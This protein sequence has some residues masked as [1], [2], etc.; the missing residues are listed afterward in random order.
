MAAKKR[1][2]NDKISYSN[3]KKLN[4]DFSKK[5]L[6]RSN[7]YNTNFTGSDFSFSSL[8]GAQ[9]KNCNFSECKFDASE[10]VATNLR[11]SKFT[12]VALKNVIMDSVNLDGVNF[13]NATFDN[14]IISNCD[15]T[16]AINLDTTTEGI[17]FFET[18][19]SLAISERLE[20]AIRSCKKN[21]YIKKSGV[22]DTKEGEINSLSVLLLLEVFS[23][24]ILISSL[25]KLKTSIDENFCTLSSFIN[26]INEANV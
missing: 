24:E 15:I 23:E 22:L 25:S 13:E 10:F 2:Q 12:N 1:T 5:D 14:V 7:C 6:K 18:T 20:R 16:K 3:R 11:N 4:A 8:K 26:M 21:E 17:R 19:P 9:F